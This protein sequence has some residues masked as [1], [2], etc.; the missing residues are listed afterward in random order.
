MDILQEETILDWSIERQSPQIKEGGA[1]FVSVCA[2]PLTSWLREETRRNCSI[3]NVL[4]SHR[5][6]GTTS[7]LARLL[8]L[9]SVSLSVALVDSLHENSE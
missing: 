7:L 1:C 4:K 6:L 8:C 9:V 3:N 5:V 2:E